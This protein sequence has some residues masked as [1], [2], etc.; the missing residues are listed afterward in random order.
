ME[1]GSDVGEQL[2]HLVARGDQHRHQYEADK[3]QDHAVLDQALTV[4]AV[5][6]GEGR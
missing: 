4:L 3:H 6:Q 2:G 5:A 1:C